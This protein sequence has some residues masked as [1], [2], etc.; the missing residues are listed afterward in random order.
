LHW[1]FKKRESAHEKPLDK[2]EPVDEHVVERSQCCDGFCTQP[3][4]GR[5]KASSG[6]H[7]GGRYQ[8]DGPVLDWGADGF[9]ASE[10]EKVSLG[11]D[12]NGHHLDQ[13]SHRLQH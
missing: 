8:A 11:D 9:A 5:R 13:F 7:R 12:C 3:S 4:H 6:G 10:K 1:A 2:E